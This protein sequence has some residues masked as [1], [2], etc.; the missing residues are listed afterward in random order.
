M[1]RLRRIGAQR[2]LDRG[3]N[4]DTL[5]TSVDRPGAVTPEN[6]KETLTR[7]AIRRKEARQKAFR[8]GASG[9]LTAIRAA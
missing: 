6:A 7:S 1:E 4:W 5:I 9:L 8:S 3:I 2:L